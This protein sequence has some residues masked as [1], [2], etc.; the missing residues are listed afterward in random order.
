V[1]CAV[2]C[3]ED[4]TGSKCT[5]KSLKRFDGAAQPVQ[6]LERA[7]GAPVNIDVLYG[8]VLVQRSISGKVEVQF[9]PF[10]YA[11]YDEQVSANQQLAQNLRTSAT[12]AGGVTVSVQRAGGTNGLGANTVVRLPDDFDGT[13]TVVNHGDGPLNEFEVKIEHVGRAN[14]LNV[15][16]QSLVGDCWIQGGPSVH[17]TTVQCG[18]Q[19][20]VF[21]VSDDV[22]ITDS[23]E[24][25]DDAAPAITLR[26]AAISPGSHGG[27]ITSTSGAISATF[28]SAGG[29]ILNAKSPVKGSVQE[30]ALPAK[31]TRAETSPA[32]KTITCGA[33]PTYEL[34]AGAK[35]EY[36]V[37]PKD[38]NVIIA[39]Q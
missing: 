15:T 9:S 27:K 10:V 3:I 12:A 31:C 34:T 7:P 26:V 28:P 36:P 35:P 20:S 22:N 16:N 29:F 33:G 37:E 6:T 24:M 19:I 13:L 32:A 11:G 17:S 4:A 23:E 14:A 21:D 30:G 39:Y 5:A 18:E 2:S 8:S 1:G 25:Y 38:S